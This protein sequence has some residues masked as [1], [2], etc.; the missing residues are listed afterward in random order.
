MWLFVI[1][2]EGVSCDAGHNSMMTGRLKTEYTIVVM[3]VSKLGRS[4]TIR[5]VQNLSRRYEKQ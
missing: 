4:E 5:S 2:F 1:R 3:E